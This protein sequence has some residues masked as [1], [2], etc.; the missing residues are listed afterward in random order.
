MIAMQAMTGIMMCAV[1]FSE[2]EA[3]RY[4]RVHQEAKQTFQGFLCHGAQHINRHLLSV[5]SLLGPLRRCCSGGA[6]RERVGMP[7]HGLPK[8]CCARVRHP[9]SKCHALS[10]L[11]LL[12]AAQGHNSALEFGPHRGRLSLPS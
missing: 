10:A 9:I 12:E 3:E 1:S 8:L 6:L 7:A 2:A 4:M 11:H 5:M